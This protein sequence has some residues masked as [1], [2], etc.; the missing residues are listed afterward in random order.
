MDIR[1]FF[2]EMWGG[3]DFQ[4]NPFINILSNR[5]NV[6][7]DS[8]NPNLVISLGKKKYLNAL[9]L[10]YNAGEPYYPS[11]SPDIA[12]HFIGS[13]FFDYENYT[14]FPSYFMYISHFIQNGIIEGFDFFQKTDREIPKK[15]KFCCFVGKSM[16]GKRGRFI[17]KLNSYKRVE[18]NSPPYND[19]QLEFDNSSFN[20]SIPKIN[21]IQ[22]YKFNIAFE[23]NFR[24]HHPAF[25]GSRIENGELVS[26]AGLTNE[27]IVEPFVAGTLPIYWGN[28]KISEEFN[29]KTF[30]NLHDFQNDEELIEKIIELDSNENLYTSYFKQKIAS[31]NNF[32]MEYL[33]DLFD[34]IIYKYKDQYFHD[35]I[36]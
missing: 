27:K 13:F 23:N 35:Q 24:G 8:S 18:T 22:K 4:N 29:S 6:T 1:L 36:S 33:S 21:F 19:F 34:N 10:Y 5:H 32:S 7:I 2:T 9:T 12:D 11:L 31:N 15:E 30:L 14:R 16:V 25:P 17:E 26:M 3:F 20:S 28:E